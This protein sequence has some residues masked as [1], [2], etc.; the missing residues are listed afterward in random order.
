MINGNS[1]NNYKAVGIEFFKPLK[2]QL[3]GKLPGMLNQLS[4]LESLGLWEIKD[5]V[6]DHSPNSAMDRDQTT[7]HGPDVP[8]DVAILC[9]VMASSLC[10]ATGAVGSNNV[11]CNDTEKKAL[12]K[13]KHDLVDDS[14]VLSSWEIQKDC[15]RWKGI[16]CNNQTG[17]V[18]VLDLHHVS[19][20]YSPEQ[21]LAG[22]ISPSLLELPYLNYLDL[23]FNSFGGL[24]IPSFIASLSKLKQLKLASCGFI[25]PIPH[26][27]GNLSN[28]LTLDLSGNYIAVNNLDW[29]SHLSSLKYLNLSGLNLSE[30]VSWPQSISKLSTL[31]ELQL[32]S[33][34]LPNVNPVSLPLINSS[35]SLQL[36]EL[37]N[38]ILIKSSIFFWV[39]NISSNLLHIGLSGCQLQG[40][41]P[42]IFTNMV[43]LES[44][45]LSYNNLEG[46][47]PKSFRNLC[48]LESLNLW[49]NNFSD[50]LH[51]SMEHLSCSEHSLKQLHLSGNPFWGPFPNLRRFLSLVDLYIDGTKLS[52]SLPEYL[53]HLSK[54]QSVSLVENH[55][56]GSL[57]DFTGLQ[58]LKMLFLARNKL[59]GSVP[60]SMGKL[61]SLE[62]L[63][64][65]SNS[66]D[67]VISEA[68]FSNL[69]RLRFLS[70]S[71]NPLSFNLSSNWIPPFQ[72]SGLD[73][74]S[75]NLGRAFPKWIRTQRKLDT[76]YLVNAGISDS[77]PN[78]FWDLSSSL[79]DLN[80]SFNKIHGKLPNL[81]SIN[82]NFFMFDL[83]SNHLHG[84]LPPFLSNIST[85]NLSKNMFS[86]PLSS[87]CPTQARTQDPKLFHLDL[88]D[89]QLSG[90][91]PNCWMQFQGIITLNLARNN[92]SGKIPHSMS[93]MEN[94]VVLRLQ[95]NNLSGEMPSFENCT[96]LSVVDMG[97]NKLSGRVP[98]WIGGQWLPKLLVL[99]LQHNEFNGNLP[100]S[101]C[102]LPALLVLDLSYNRISGLLPQCLNNIT[103]MSNDVEVIIILGL[104]K[105]VWKGLEVEFGQNLRLLRT[106]DISSNHLSGAIPD[107]I[108]SLL[109]LVS[110][111]LSRNNLDGNIPSKFGELSM[112]EA[113]DLSRNQI[114]GSIPESF[115]NLNF[116]GVLDLSHNNLRGRIPLGTQLQ[117]F[118]ASAYIGNEGLCGKPLPKGCPGDEIPQVP[119][120]TNG[121]EQGDDDDDDDDGFISFG[122]YLSIGIG[123][124][125]GFWGVCGPLVLKR[126][127]KCAYHVL[128][129]IRRSC[130]HNF[131]LTW[132]LCMVITTSINLGAASSNISRCIEREKQALLKFK[133]D[134]VGS[135]NTLASW[136][137]KECCKWRGIT[138][139]NH[140]AIPHEIR[141]LS[142][143]HTLDLSDNYAI[144]VDN[145]QWLS[146]LSSL[147]YLDISL[148][149]LSEAVSWLQ[150]INKL[151]S[152]V[153]HLNRC[154]LPDAD[155]S[156]L[157]HINS[158]KSLQVLELSG[159]NQF[160]G[161]FPELT[162]FPSLELL[163]LQ[164]NN[165]NGSLTKCFG[166][167]SQVR[168]LNLGFNRFRGSLPDFTG[169]TSLE[170]L[171]LSN[172]QLNGS[173][174]ESVGQLSRLKMLD[175]S[176]NSLSGVIKEGHFLNLSRSQYLYISNNSLSFNLTSDWIPPFQLTALFAASCKLGPSF[177]KWLST[178][179]KLQSLDISK[180][181][182][183]DSIPSWFWD[184]SPSLENM[185]LSFNQ[186]HGMLPNLSS[187]SYSTID[188]SSNHLYGPLPSF[189]PNTTT[190]IL[191]NNMF[192]G[193]ISS[194]C[195]TRLSLLNQLELSHNILSGELPTCWM[196][197]NNNFSGEIPNSLGKLSQIQILH[198]RLNNFSEE[199]PFLIN[200]SGLVPL[201]L[202]ENRISG[203][204]PEWL[205]KNLTSL[206]VL[207]LKSNGF[208]GS[209]PIS[210]CS[211]KAIQIL[212]LSR[213]N[214]SGVLPQYLGNL[215]AMSSLGRAE[216][217]IDFAT[218]WWKGIETELGRNLKFLRSID[219]SSNH[220]SGKI[221][222]TIT[223]LLVLNSLNLSRNNFRGSIPG[224]LGQ[225]K[226]L[227]SLDLSR[228]Q[229]SGRI[230][231]NTQLQSFSAS[232]CAGNQGLCGLPLTKERPGDEKTTDR[233]PDVSSG[234]ENDDELLNLG[235]YVN[236]AVGFF[237]GFWGVCGTL[238]LKSSWRY[239]Y[240]QFLNDPKDWIHVTT[241]VFKVRLQR[242]IAQIRF[243]D[244]SVPAIQWNLH[245]N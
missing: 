49:Q 197:A 71:Y 122:F 184:M 136:E 4:E 7:T 70:I 44:L 114:S 230:P 206:R 57:P 25:G 18:M 181:D 226:E 31:I 68:Q 135:S 234:D 35:T 121:N 12:L 11:M 46:G 81:S 84:P 154:D 62:N 198:L 156:S 50:R 107:S 90:N 174:P 166:Q 41:V 137:P 118:G 155:P 61:S 97:R 173:V 88:S 233:E 129:T 179:R 116:L 33:C 123:Y 43:S 5:I 208:Y 105:V 104:V 28:L 203:K 225:L 144:T 17:H 215:T 54:L 86:G 74:I 96:E 163:S 99:R 240:L 125:V 39:A 83:S 220:F 103:S 113:L 3:Q 242:R 80:L 180:A 6:D 231:L 59:N 94:I 157:P 55:F 195:S 47:I 27:L 38:N 238:V 16:A 170:E 205:G 218:L 15:C 146:H 232:S 52:G 147:K 77:I 139:N 187:K 40:P 48:N 194:L 158:S 53:G 8:G 66:L 172:N 36:L 185:N 160:R 222:R 207:R 42:D 204:I 193:P 117:S 34:N 67:G 189:S 126:C 168:Y 175:L 153:E 209:M 13:F 93:Y 213:N 119:S 58:S 138:Y 92:F 45:D 91:L 23:S 108:T 236:L 183:S 19:D 133:Q 140:T 37:S 112:L 201:D 109:K 26:Q 235:F 76:L 64:L 223:R 241:M 85:V 214:L 72:L 176:S 89:N 165:L 63:D 56:T 192:S 227:E 244:I 237:M 200:C 221:P 148:L 228:N 188:L 131:A 87:L 178:Q 216:G 29:L 21:P 73:I 210:L 65:S 79:V 124:F 130:I 95:D 142:L 14:D 191:S 51:D 115:S 145:L 245:R 217:L 162:R 171:Y 10:F 151:T 186:I 120:V 243:L 196:Q 110:L 159:Y 32:S 199:M 224:M 190:L 202:G 24:G 75:C 167:L 69:S 100:S 182:I 150:S 149:D 101:L 169:Q 20:Y 152:L 1:S 177:P 132:V 128:F 60:E 161:S 219:I 141:N 111:N 127:W 82:S 212:D 2:D 164:H 22:E 78:E 9:V 134:L 102:S 98:E 143:L 106:I 211:L 239:A 30:A 229:L